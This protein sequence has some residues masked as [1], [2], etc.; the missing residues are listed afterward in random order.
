MT[1]TR[2]S[3]GKIKYTILIMW[4]N[5]FILY[6]PTG[7][8]VTI[9]SFYG[10]LIYTVLYCLFKTGHLCMLSNTVFEIF[11]DFFVHLKIAI[12]CQTMYCK[13]LPFN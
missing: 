10:V 1:P 5:V 3:S 6:R 8:S 7:S 11:I 9:E 12:N 2:I 4:L 13:R